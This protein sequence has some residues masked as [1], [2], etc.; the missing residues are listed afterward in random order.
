[1]AVT[2]TKDYVGVPRDSEAG[3]G[4]KQLVYASWDGHLL[5]AAPFMLAATPDTPFGELV[6]G[7]IAG[8][9][10]P[11]PDASSI[12]WDTVEW[13]LGNEPWTP[14]F[15]R[16]LADNGVRHKMEVRFHTPGL[17]TLCRV[18]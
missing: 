5:F 9:I 15:S 10:A 4:G 17:N 2:S 7:Q 11:D 14:D 3:F 8:L 16:S 1:M 6:H 12:D 13:R 18:A